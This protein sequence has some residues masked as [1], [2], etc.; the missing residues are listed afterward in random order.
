MI[1]RWLKSCTCIKPIIMHPEPIGPQQ[2]NKSAVASFGE[3][4]LQE[5]VEKGQSTLNV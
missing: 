4:Y 1:S 3:S 2:S 5:F